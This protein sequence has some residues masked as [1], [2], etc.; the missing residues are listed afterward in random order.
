MF[1]KSPC[2]CF[3]FHTKNTLTKVAHFSKISY[4]ASFHDPKAGGVLV[5]PTSQVRASCTLVIVDE[6]GAGIASNGTTFTPSFF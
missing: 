2:Y 1:A 5:D 6:F 4:R 3:T